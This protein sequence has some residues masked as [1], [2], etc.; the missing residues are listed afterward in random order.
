[1]SPKTYALVGILCGVAFVALIL[2]LS[3]FGTEPPS[4]DE[5]IHAWVLAHRSPASLTIAQGIT[6]GGAVALVLPLTVIVGTI[7]NRSENGFP[8]RLRAG[9]LVAAS[10]GIGIYLGLQINS[11]TA[12]PRPPLAD[13]VSV[14][15][16]PAFPSGHTTAATIFA[17][18]CAWVI[19]A[20]VG[21][22]WP[23]R[24]VWLAAVAFAV[25]VG[26]SRVWL[27]VH[28]PTDVL[29]GW[30]WGVAWFGT[31]TAV[32]LLMR[33]RADKRRT[34]RPAPHPRLESAR[35]S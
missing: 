6:W 8:K 11:W 21:E 29:G 2:W 9:L 18:S 24:V 34:T 4:L 26:W 31:A 35:R 10:A 16:G 3:R 12:R 15:G 17:A 30:L 20:R 5:R 19:A 32:I 27:G 7:T 22:G 28:W 1:V 14:A 23:R 33:Q 25:A 13:W